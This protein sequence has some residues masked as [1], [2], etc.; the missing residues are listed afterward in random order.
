MVLAIGQKLWCDI[1]IPK[2]QK[3][4]F[5]KVQLGM[6]EE[7]VEKSLSEAPDFVIELE[8]KTKIWIY[9]MLSPLT[10]GKYAKI[11]CEMLKSAKNFRGRYEDLLIYFNQEGKVIA[12]SYVGEMKK[13]SPEAEAAGIPLW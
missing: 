3:G 5:E 13:Q 2:L 6:T 10:V 1:T 7:D 9:L 12:V 11:N 8:D 4:R